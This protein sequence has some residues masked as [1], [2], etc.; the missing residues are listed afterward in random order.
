MTSWSCDELT[1]TRFLHEKATDQSFP[2]LQKLKMNN[3][4]ARK[5]NNY[6]IVEDD[7]E[8]GFVNSGAVQSISPRQV[9]V[10]KKL[11]EGKFAVVKTGALTV[12]NESHPVAVKMLRRT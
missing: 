9:D 5:D 10:G 1:G 12:N 7:D 2:L 8:Y 4:R 6:N 3:V 11:A